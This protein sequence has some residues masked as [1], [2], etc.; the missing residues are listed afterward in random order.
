MDGGAHQSRLTAKLQRYPYRH[1]GQLVQP[2]CSY[3]MTYPSRNSG[4]GSCSF[5]NHSGSCPCV[6]SPDGP[7]EPYPTI[8]TCTTVLMLDSCVRVLDAY[9]V[10]VVPMC[11]R[12]HRSRTA[13]A[14]AATP[15]KR[16]T[17]G[18]SRVVESGLLSPSLPHPSTCALAPRLTPR[19]TDPHPPTTSDTHRFEFSP[20]KKGD[21]VIGDCDHHQLKNGQALTH[22]HTHL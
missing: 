2:L 19:L 21:P 14:T 17:L 12:K 3:P 7:Y 16:S 8:R 15:T 10:Q 20:P 4:D 5:P 13:P 22:S 1:A 9:V 6:F 18:T 11:E